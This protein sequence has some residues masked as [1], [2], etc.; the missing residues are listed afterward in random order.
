MCLRSQAQVVTNSVSQRRVS[1]SCKSGR[2]TE[3]VSA[4]RLILQR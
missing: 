3:K 2:E 4:E 1:Q